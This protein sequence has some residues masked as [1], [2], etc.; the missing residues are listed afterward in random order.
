MSLS[1]SSSFLEKPYGFGAFK[2]GGKGCLFVMLA[3]RRQ[4][5]EVISRLVILAVEASFLKSSSQ[6]LSVLLGSS[7]SIISVSEA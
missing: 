5:T 6:A 3:E 1:S 2:Y 7:S 4:S